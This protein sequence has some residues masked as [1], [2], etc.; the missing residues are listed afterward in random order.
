MDASKITEIEITLHNIQLNIESKENVQRETEKTLTCLKHQK[1]KILTESREILGLGLFKTAVQ[2]HW[3]KWVEK[4]DWINA[5]VQD[6]E[7]C[8]SVPCTRRIAEL[9]NEKFGS[10][11]SFKY[12]R[13]YSDLPYLY[14][15]PRFQFQEANLELWTR[16]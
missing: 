13:D 11:F 3:S 1:A 15:C 12:G 5:E 14:I 2:Q 4:P 10:Y 7:G 16:L 6:L 8:R 9:L